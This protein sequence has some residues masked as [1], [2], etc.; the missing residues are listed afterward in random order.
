MSKQVWNLDT[1]H[2]DITFKVRHMMI[3]NVGG[4]FD[5][6]TGI[7]RSSAKD[8]SDAEIAF[9]ADMASVNTRNEQRDGHLKSPDFF[10]VA[11]FP[12]MN[13]K[14][15]TFKKTGDSTYQMTG[16]FTLKGV[17]KEITLNVEHTGMVVDIWGQTKA[18][19]E[20]TGT[21]NRSDYG[22]FWNA[23]TEDGGVALAE[24]VKLSMNIQMIKQA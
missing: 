22:L 9:E 19:F 13:F 23:N 21:V 11:T 20:I 24:E 12:V 2:S 14:S 17:A 4:T 7:M 8:F 3:T 15:T 10:D 18:G 16:I 6:C 1:V 5:R